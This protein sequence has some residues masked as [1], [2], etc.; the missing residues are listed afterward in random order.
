M[1]H[2]LLLKG[3][4]LILA[5]LRFDDSII[6]MSYME[7]LQSLKGKEGSTESMLLESLILYRLGKMG[8]SVD[9]YH[10]LPKSMIDSLEINLVAGLVSV[11][12]TSEG[13]DAYLLL[14]NNIGIVSEKGSNANRNSARGFNVNDDIKSTLEKECVTIR[15]YPQVATTVLTVTSDHKLTHELRNEEHHLY[16]L[17]YIQFGAPR[18]FYGVPGSY[19]CKFKKAVTKYLP[20][21]SAHPRLLHNHVTQF[22]PSTL[23][24]EGLPVYRCVKPAENVVEL[25]RELDRKTSISYNKLLLEA[26]AET[27][28]SLG[29]LSRQNKNSHVVRSEVHRGGRGRRNYALIGLPFL[30]IIL[31]T[32]VLEGANIARYVDS[33]L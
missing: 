6:L 9:I 12:R 14:D 4:L 16:L 7:A 23:T 15:G 31:G 18:I 20:Q 26:T 11:G 22:S 2:W 25:Y 27:I 28:R 21:L 13:C 29:E 17:T 3:L 30:F 33:K 1:K 32:A 5:S 10:K 24:S 19:R 8:A